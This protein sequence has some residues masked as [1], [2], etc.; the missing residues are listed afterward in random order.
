MPYPFFVF[1]WENTNIYVKGNIMTKK[2]QFVILA[3]F[4]VLAIISCVSALVVVLTASNQA[5]TS[6]VNV[7]YTASDVYVK[8]K[9]NYYIGSNTVAMINGDDTEVVLSPINHSGSLNQ[10]NAKTTSALMDVDSGGKVVFEYI[11]ENLSGTVPAKISQMTNADGTPYVPTDTY[12]NVNVQYVGT[13]KV[14]GASAYGGK[15][16]ISDI[17]ILPLSTKYIYVIVSVKDL[18]HNVQYKG[19][20]GWMLSRADLVDNTTENVSGG[21]IISGTDGTDVVNKDEMEK[22]NLVLDCENEKPNYY[23]QKANKCF[24][25][26]YTKDESGNDIEVEWPALITSSTKIYPKYEDET[27]GLSYTYT[28]DGYAIVGGYNGSTSNIF[29][30]DIHNDG[31]HGN[32]KITSIAAFAFQ[33]NSKITT[34]KI[35]NTI[36]TIGN[37]SFYGCSNLQS[38]YIPKS[39]VSIMEEAFVNCNSLTKIVVEEGNPVYDSRKDCNSINET[40]SNAI[41]LGCVSTIIPDTITTIGSSA[42][43]HNRNIEEITFPL[44]VRSID[45]YAF[46]GCTGITTLNIPDNIK[47]IGDYAF[48]AC[49]GLTELYIS[50]G[51]TKIGNN[52]FS[53]NI[54]LAKI[55]VA[56]DNPVYDSRDN[57]NA[58]IE[59]ETNAMTY[60]CYNTIIPE[61]VKSLKGTSFFYCQKLKNIYIP[62]NV[63]SISSLS[64]AGCNNVETIQIDEANTKYDSRNNCNAII[65]TAKNSLILGCYKSTIPNTVTTI[66]GSAFAGQSKITAINIP[67]SVKSIGNRVFDE[68]PNIETVVVDANNTV[69]DSRNNCNAIIETATNKLV[70]GCQNT[71][72]PNTVTELGFYSFGSV[73]GLTEI[74]IPNSVTVLGESAFSSCH[75]LTSITLPNSIVSIKKNAFAYCVNLQSITLPSSLK[76]IGANTFG[77]CEKITEIVFVDS[78]GWKIYDSDTSTSG[79]DVTISTTD[80]Y[81][82]S[83]LLKAVYSGKVWKKG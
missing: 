32:A 27:T 72:I 35:P 26:W 47:T 2:K 4:V 48:Y 21:T 83:T 23:P 55:S 33:S 50:S 40:I 75:A 59:T 70:L 68:C 5:S 79:E 1:C 16:T 67:A 62:K 81:Y 19:S 31:T 3:I 12:N 39:V 10:P 57:C 8:I 14:M 73:T 56:K 58:I 15:D 80:L 66:G 71:V 63:E 6:K 24:T 52:S 53:Y 25:G 7:D 46:Y 29:V 69:Y 41:V 34:L 18:M 74:T 44:S 9:A 36:T 20:F 49:S 78:T 51:V 17:A 42:F 22:I 54:N 64:F 37:R 11:F 28:G 82:N 45:D 65:E 76:Y 77:R 43:R 61:S 30:P 38:L 13:S 60:G